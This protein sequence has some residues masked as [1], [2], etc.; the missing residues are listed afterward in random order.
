MSAAGPSAQPRGRRARTP[1]SG[2]DAAG[3]PAPELLKALARLDELLQAIGH[4]RAAEVAAASALAEVDPP[5][6]WRALDTNAWWAG[7]GSLAAETLAEN[8]GLS[9][10]DWALAVREFRELLAEIGEALMDRG[11]ANP[12][13]SSWVL[14]FRNWNA[15]GV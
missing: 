1:Q 3:P 7:A 8:P 5:A 15:S 9:A 4:P 12:G 11:T 6:F 10:A 14:A 13:I 2:D